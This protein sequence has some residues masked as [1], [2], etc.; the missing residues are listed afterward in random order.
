MDLV[1]NITQIAAF[2]HIIGYIFP[3]RKVKHI[4][5]HNIIDDELLLNF[6][7]KFQH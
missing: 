4:V 7:P 5:Y 6:G 3:F 1:Y 2:L